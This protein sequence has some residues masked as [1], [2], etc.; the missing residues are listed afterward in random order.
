M[1]HAV[2]KKD[3]TR[4]CK[5][6]AS[7]FLE[8]EHTFGTTEIRLLKAEALQ[9]SPSDQVAD[10]P[11]RHRFSVSPRQSGKHNTAISLNAVYQQTQAPR[12]L[13]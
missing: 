1:V 4:L 13:A 3:L 5:V 10:S 6:V 9:P 7:P 12:P 11:L 2:G 8:L